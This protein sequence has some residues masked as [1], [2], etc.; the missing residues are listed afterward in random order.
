MKIRY[1]L[2]DGGWATAEVYAGDDTV[3]MGVSYLRNSLKELVQAAIDLRNSNAS[4]SVI[5]MDEPG[6]HHLLF[7]KDINETVSVEIR[8][9][10]DWASQGILPKD[11]Y[12]SVLTTK[13]TVEDVQKEIIN[14]LEAILD[15]YGLKTYKEKWIE[16]E[17]P[18]AEYQYLKAIQK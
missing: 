14:L 15:K 12:T 18:I 6:E 17:F 9:Y 4:A 10:E 8:W 11:Q 2:E 5:F 16:H 3:E 1:A 13:T 7:K